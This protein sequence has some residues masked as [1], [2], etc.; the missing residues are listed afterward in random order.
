M[1]LRKRVRRKG[2]PGGQNVKGKKATD[3][4]LFWARLPRA[5]QRLGPARVL[6]VGCFPRGTRQRSC[7][8][9][10]GCIP[11]GPSQECC[12]DPGALAESDKKWKDLTVK[13]VSWVGSTCFGRLEDALRGR[14][15]G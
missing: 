9:P 3:R 15:T 11:D 1:M 6:D 14:Q 13:V 7:R 8:L 4:C 5:G 12:W 10:R 2:V